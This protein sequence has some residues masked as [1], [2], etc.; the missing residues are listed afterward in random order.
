[1]T[2]ATL[3]MCRDPARGQ[4]SVASNQ[5]PLGRTRISDS[6]APDIVGN[7]WKPARHPDNTIIA[8]NWKQ[9]PLNRYVYVDAPPLLSAVETPYYTARSGAPSWTGIINTWN[10]A[11]W[12]PKAQEMFIT[13]G[14]HFAT[15]SCETGIYRLKADTLLFDRVKNRDPQSENGTWTISNGKLVFT[16]GETYGS[17]VLKSSQHGAIH[18]YHGIVWV[19]PEL[20]A[21][22]RGDQLNV[23]G[24]IF[25][26]NIIRYVYDLDAKAYV[27]MPNWR[28]SPDSDIDISDSAA[29]IDGTAIYGP[30]HSFDIWKWELT[31][32]QNT[33]WSPKS[34]GVFTITHRSWG[35]IVSSHSVWGWLP[36][37]REC[38]GF[39]G[40]NK[41]NQLSYQRARYGQA[42]DQKA[43]SWLPYVDNI[44]LT[45]TDGSHL[46]FSKDNLSSDNTPAGNLYGAGSVYD[47]ETGTLHI[48]GSNAG[49]PLYK[50]TGL[51]GNAWTTQKIAGAEALAYSQNGVFGRLRLAT[52]GGRKII[53]RVSGVDHRTQVMRIS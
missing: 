35:H 15:S 46:D 10:G 7:L 52:L 19:P 31:G 20:M 18:T 51:D 50:V 42:I 26:T 38:F 23:S 25:L 43:A 29:F 37:R 45:S 39:Y 53:I 40:S 47:H 44:R 27:G 36:E 1:M 21:I 5:I 16:P 4:G 3:L 28:K 41:A 30:H 6:A 9:L 14:G 49:A 11:A 13:G 48:Q 32:T 12:N 22:I 17:V 2:G 24:G 33:N 34:T 8:N